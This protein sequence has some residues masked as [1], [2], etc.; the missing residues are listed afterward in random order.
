MLDSIYDTKKGIQILVC[1]YG[2]SHGEIIASKISSDLKITFSHTIK[3]MNLLEKWGYITKNK[4]GRKVL[5]TLTLMGKRV[6]KKL[7]EIKLEKK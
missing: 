7:V 4:S 1:I 5:V 3:I 2:Y 6:A